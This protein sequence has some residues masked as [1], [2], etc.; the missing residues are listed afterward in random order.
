M[1]EKSKLPVF[2]YST[3]ITLYLTLPT[4]TNVYASICSP[5]NYTSVHIFEYCIFPRLLIIY[6]SE[7]IANS[8]VRWCTRPRR[9]CYDDRI[10]QNAPKNLE[11]LPKNRKPEM[12]ISTKSCHKLFSVVQNYFLCIFQIIDRIY[13]DPIPQNNLKKLRKTGN[14]EMWISTKSC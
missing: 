4:D 3:S 14:L 9:L 10:A 6:S 12:R 11:N 2:F 1:G 13:D 5:C 7:L 8:R